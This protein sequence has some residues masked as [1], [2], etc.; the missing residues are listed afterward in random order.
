MTIFVIIMILL[1]I[2]IFIPI[3]I[4]TIFKN[5]NEE[6]VMIINVK[7]LFFTIKKKVSKP[8]TK[9]LA[10]SSRKNLN[11]QEIKEATKADKV[12]KKN[13]KII[14]RRLK[15]SFPKITEVLKKSMRVSAKIIKPIKCEKLHLY[16]EIG[17]LDPAL[18]GVIVGVLWSMQGILIS[19]L[20]K[21]M[22]LKSEA[23][24]IKVIPR[25]N[26]SKFDF[27]YE[28]IIVF[29]LGHIIIVVYEFVRFFKVSKY[30]LKEVVQ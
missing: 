28:S 26:E 22:E 1:L 4:H 24:K 30:L 12:P 16:T 17:L 13:W 18:T 19:Q 9:I 2:M 25:Y 6:M 20:T 14:Y 29:P 15:K 27:N 3:R 10:L 11:T 21:Y 7:I 8:F 23:I 5:V